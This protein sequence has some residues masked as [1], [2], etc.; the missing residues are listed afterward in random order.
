[1]QDDIIS[2]T[3][4]KI[5]DIKFIDSKRI[6]PAPISESATS[7]PPFSQSATGTIPCKQ[8]DLKGTH[9]LFVN[10][11]FKACKLN[12]YICRSDDNFPSAFL[13][14][15]KDYSGKISLLMHEFYSGKPLKLSCLC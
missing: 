10:K 13:K 11:Y 3:I 14:E 12:I 1:M 8:V 4:F 6:N 2:S 5:H 9:K 7:T 15:L